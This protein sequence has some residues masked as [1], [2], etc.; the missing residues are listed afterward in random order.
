MHVFL[1]WSVLFVCFPAWEQIKVIVPK[2]CQQLL[3]YL[4]IIIS[5]VYEFS[6]GFRIPLIGSVINMLSWK[7]Y[8]YFI[9]FDKYFYML[10]TMIF[11]ELKHKLWCTYFSS[12]SFV[13]TIN[14]VFVNMWPL[15]ITLKKCS[16]NFLSFSI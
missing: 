7:L 11:Q 2:L 12:H 9:F 5:S 6:V 16:Y 15:I 3:W 1:F 14:N 4:Y 8:T 13:Y 10:C